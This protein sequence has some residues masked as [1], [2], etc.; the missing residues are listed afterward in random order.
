[1]RNEYIN[2]L[3]KEGKTD[4]EIKEGG[5]KEGRKNGRKHVRQSMKERRKE[6]RQIFILLIC[7]VSKLELESE[8]LWLAGPSLNQR[9]GGS[10]PALIDVPLSKT[11]NPE[12]LP[13]AVYE[14]NMIISRFG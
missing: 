1:M 4:E 5:C 9:V 3:C 7:F 10:I 6:G 14:C 13:V 12:C 8:R 2:E 11:L